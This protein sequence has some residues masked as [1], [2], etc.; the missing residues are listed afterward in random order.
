MPIGKRPASKVVFSYNIEALNVDVGA[1]LINPR[2]EGE[3]D[4]SLRLGARPG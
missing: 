4:D 2:L 1:K 3:N